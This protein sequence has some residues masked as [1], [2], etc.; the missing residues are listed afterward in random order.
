MP[1]ELA[2]LAVATAFAA[3]A[4]PPVQDAYTGIRKLLAKLVA[5]R[6]PLSKALD[7]AMADAWR[8]FEGVLRAYCYLDPPA[9]HRL[10]SFARDPRVGEVL[11][12]LSYLHPTRVAGV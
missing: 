1:I 5:R 9:E 4:A 6:S 11:A 7:R 2:S 12:Q 3:L 10:Q 8:A